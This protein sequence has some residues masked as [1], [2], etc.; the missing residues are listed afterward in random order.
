MIIGLIVGGV[1]VGRDL[2]HASE[3]RSTISQLEKY[4]AAVNT[5][6]GKYNCLPGDCA[7]GENFG[8]NSAWDGNGDGIIGPS[9][10]TALGMWGSSNMEP[11]Y[12]WWQLQAAGLIKD[13]FI[14]NDDYQLGENTPQAY[15][16]SMPLWNNTAGWGIIADARF[17]PNYGGGSLAAH[18]FVLGDGNSGSIIYGAYAPADMFS[19][20]TKVDDGLPLSGRMHAFNYAPVGNSGGASYWFGCANMTACTEGI[21]PGG[22]GTDKCVRNDV[23]PSA[24]NVLSTMADSGGVCGAVIK[25]SF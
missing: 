14:V 20:D 10:S 12:F 11:G 3:I 21:G 1:M 7:H 4:N 5:F 19:I 13:P 8:F 6:Q 22:S 15:I 9:S 17:S 2:I 25:A 16:T 24:Y 18:S 23:S